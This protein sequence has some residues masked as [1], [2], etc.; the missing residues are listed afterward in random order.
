MKNNVFDLGKPQDL[1][2]LADINGNI[3]VTCSKNNLEW[4]LSGEDNQDKKISKKMIID[5]ILNH[6]FIGCNCWNFIY[7]Q[8]PSRLK[9]KLINHTEFYEVV[10]NL[11]D[12]LYPDYDKKVIEN[13]IDEIE[14]VITDKTYFVQIAT[15]PKISYVVDVI[16]RQ[17]KT[18]NLESETYLRSLIT[19][20]PQLLTFVK[21]YV[22][23][24]RMMG[25][26]SWTTFNH[27]SFNLL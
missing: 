4:F 18:H 21:F 9:S 5:Q 12:F 17:N 14:K 6:F 19:Q 23:R 27:N 24:L 25:P 26:Y 8:N 2:N 16:N 22:K 1:L 7:D 10:F 13:F 15:Y 3:S 11:S 20:N